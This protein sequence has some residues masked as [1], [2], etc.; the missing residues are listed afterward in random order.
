VGWAGQIARAE[1]S[2]GAATRERSMQAN[3]DQSTNTGS[4]RIKDAP[5][6]VIDLLHMVA[7][8]GGHRASIHAIVPPPNGTQGPCALRPATLAATGRPMASQTR[9]LLEDR[10]PDVVALAAPNVL[11][12]LPDHR[13]PVRRTSSAGWDRKL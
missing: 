11:S 10:R 7:A 5:A 13:Q 8:E 2:A 3:V 6:V 12:C 4:D 1:W 9:R